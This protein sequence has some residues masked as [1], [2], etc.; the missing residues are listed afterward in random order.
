[1]GD[2]PDLSK[3]TTP[4][5]KDAVDRVAPVAE[6]LRTT[7]Q[8]GKADPAALQSVLGNFNQMQNEAKNACG[9]V[10]IGCLRILEGDATARAISPNIPTNQFVETC[11]ETGSA[12]RSKPPKM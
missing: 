3:I 11:K 10:D 12:R 9:G 8:G 4:E 1:M 6:K 5:C 2:R 7:V